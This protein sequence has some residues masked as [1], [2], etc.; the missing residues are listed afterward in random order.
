MTVEWLNTDLTQARVTRGRWFWKRQ[1]YVELSGGNWRHPATGAHLDYHVAFWLD[2][3]RRDEQAR[4]EYEIHWPRI[5]RTTLQ[6]PE[7]RVTAK[8]KLEVVR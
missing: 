1:A 6:L 4:R 8:T 2:N 3:Q 7:A 5:R